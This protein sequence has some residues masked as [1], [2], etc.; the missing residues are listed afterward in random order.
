MSGLVCSCAVMGHLIMGTVSEPGIRTQMEWH[1]QPP[2]YRGCVE[3]S[4][5]SIRGHVA[6]H[7][8]KVIGHHMTWVRKKMAHCREVYLS[9]L[10]QIEELV[11]SSVSHFDKWLFTQSP[12][13]VF[14]NNFELVLDGA[15]MSSP[16]E[17]ALFQRPTPCCYSSTFVTAKQAPSL[18]FL[19]L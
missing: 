17:Q 7:A 4:H 12:A 9:V 13:D 16:V 6:C 5:W 18:I 10:S 8:Q 3:Y 2:A 15:I 1:T 19:S 14:Q 11:N